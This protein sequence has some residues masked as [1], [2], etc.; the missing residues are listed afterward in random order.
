MD[1]QGLSYK[2][3]LKDNIDMLIPLVE[4]YGELLIKMQTLGYEI[5]TWKTDSFRMN[6]QEH[7]TR[8]KT[9]GPNYTK[10]AIIERIKNKSITILPEVKKPTYIRIWKYDQKLGLIENTGKYLLFIQSPYARE[11]A[12]I[13]DAKKLAAT[14]NLLK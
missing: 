13:A 2:K 10:E 3:R 4:S 1:K 14:Y 8:S 9:L 12:A 5:K 6:G 11:R 7:F